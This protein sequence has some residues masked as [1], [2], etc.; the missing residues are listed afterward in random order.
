M[1]PRHK[2]RLSLDVQNRE[3][4]GR[5]KMENNLEYWNKLSSPPAWARKA[6]KGGRLNGK[7]DIN[8]QWRMRAM[9]ELFGPCGEGW[10]YTIEKLWSEPGADDQIMAMALVTVCWRTESGWSE[11]IPGIGGSML[12]EKEK[13]GLHTSDEGYKMAV[14]DGLSVAFKAI[15]VGADIYQGDEW[16]SKYKD[17][18]PKQPPAPKPAPTVADYNA[19]LKKAAEAQGKPFTPF[20]TIDAIPPQLREWASTRIAA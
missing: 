2:R 1:N 19:L 16:Q 3:I 6:I 11:P 14:T 5:E 17:R 12:V 9:T 10:K 15:G 20:E 4:K 18:E 13:S 8:P 7:T